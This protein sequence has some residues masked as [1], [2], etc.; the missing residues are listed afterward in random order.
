[1]RIDQVVRVFK[2]IA[3][4]FLVLAARI[5]GTF[6]F[7]YVAGDP[8]YGD[9]RAVLHYHAAVDLK[10]YSIA[11]FGYAVYLVDGL[12]GAAFYLIRKLL[13]DEIK[14]VG[15]GDVLHIEGHRLFLRVTEDL[16][17]GLVNRNV[18]AF[19]VV[20]VDQIVG[21][22]KQLPISCLA[23]LK[24]IER[25]FPFRNI[26]NNALPT[27]RLAGLVLDKAAPVTYPNY[28]AV[29][30]HDAVLA[31][32]VL[33]FF[34][35]RAGFAEYTLFVV[36]MNYP[37]PDLTVIEPVFQRIAKFLKCRADVDRR[38]RRRWRHGI[39]HHRQ[40]LDEPLERCVILSV[41][42]L[43]RRFFDGWNL[44]LFVLDC[45]L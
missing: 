23:D 33:A 22:L 8:L 44:Q 18:V 20:D 34:H 27:E 30:A 41:A 40:V 24:G 32:D 28:A 45:Q 19:K 9:R 35:R 5:F 4:A 14:V 7:C 13:A 39:E 25:L 11:S 2:Q 1:M 10:G 12:T 21:A 36:G 16:L 26:E 3:V 29:F 17:R 37:V 6:A 43:I 15:G 31:F 42:R 38:M